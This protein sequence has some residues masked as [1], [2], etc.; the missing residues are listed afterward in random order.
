MRILFGCALIVFSTAQVSQAGIL[1]DLLTLDGQDNVLEDNS[2]GV[3]SDLDQN[4]VVSVGD[5]FT[6]LLRID[7]RI[8]PSATSSMDDSQQVVLA[9]SLEVDQIDPI[10]GGVLHAIK[11]KAASAGTGLDIESLLDDESKPAGFTDWA[12]TAIAVME[13]TF[14]GNTPANNPVSNT[15]TAGMTLIGSV[16]GAGSGY[17]LDALVGFGDDTDFYHNLIF[18]GAGL[19]IPAIKAANG[20]STLG[21]QSGGLSVLYSDLGAA[22]SVFLPVTATSV[23]NNVSS[24]HDIGVEGGILFGNN[25]SNWDFA[26]KANI[27]LNVV[28]EPASVLLVGLLIGCLGLARWGRKI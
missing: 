11:Y 15:T 25:E 18:S 1:T 28:P 6:G 17:T 12:S 8:S 19:S 4:D 14:G 22:A 9:Y 21:T 7:R 5:V 3:I 23:I 10:A 26:D 20:S 16:L 24:P 2:R 27:R 13:R